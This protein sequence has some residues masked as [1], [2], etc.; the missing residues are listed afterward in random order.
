M[1][2][3]RAKFQIILI[4]LLLFV[5]LSYGVVTAQDTPKGLTGVHIYFSQDSSEA[6]LFD[7][8]SDGLSR[9]AGLFQQLGAEMTTLDWHFDIPA[10]A[11]LVIIPG[12]TK[13]LTGE[14]MARLWVYLINGGKLLLFADP[15]AASTSAGVTV[16]DS[17]KALT[18]AKGFF[19]LTWAD[20]G[21][22]G[23]DDV[24]LQKDAS[25]VPALTKSE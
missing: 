5:T 19:E 8:S 12:P 25:G 18:S 14:Q 10:D 21:I 22:R 23:Q 20:F 16:I 11:S 6:S 17:N 24:L 9:M 1:T 3:H 7:R 13:D 15:L 2:I 4:L